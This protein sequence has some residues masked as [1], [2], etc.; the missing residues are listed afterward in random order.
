VKAGTRIL[1]ASAA[2]GVAVAVGPFARAG[3]AAGPFAT[4]YAVLES[5]RCRNCHPA[6]NAPL[7]G[8][9]PKRHAMNVTRTS[10]AS[11]LACTTCHGATNAPFTHGPPGRPA[12]R[13]PDADM[14][15][16]FEGRSEHALCEQLKNPATNGGKSLAALEE[17]FDKDP[18]VLWGWDPGPGRTVP[19]GSHADL[20]TAVRAWIAGGAACP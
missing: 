20:V 6:G 16:V 17:H 11:G 9:V 18:F 19:P 8:D 14:P 2:L 3:D 12:W 13:L 4:I 10:A 15:L 1:L 7:Q 5:P